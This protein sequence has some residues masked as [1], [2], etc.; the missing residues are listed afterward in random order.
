MGP[1][2]RALLLC[3]QWCPKERFHYGA[4]NGALQRGLH[5]KGPRGSIPEDREW[6]LIRGPDPKDCDVL[7][8]RGSLEEALPQRG[9]FA[10][11]DCDTKGSV[12]WG[13]VGSSQEQ[14][15]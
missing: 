3:T 12:H 11:M 10:L 15:W 5:N 1:K 4:R 7:Q 6:L 13:W 9:G 2:G 14:T 8:Q